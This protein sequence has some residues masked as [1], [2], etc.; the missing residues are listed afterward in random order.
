MSVLLNRI[1]PQAVRTDIGEVL[2]AVVATSLSVPHRL[3]H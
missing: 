1:W 3:D 2:D